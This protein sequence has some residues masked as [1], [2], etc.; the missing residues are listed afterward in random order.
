MTKPTSKKIGRPTKKDATSKRPRGAILA[1]FL[2]QPV[3]EH[4]RASGMFEETADHRAQSDHDD[5]EAQRVAEA[6]L[7]R[8]EDLFRRH[9]RGQAERHAGE[10]QRQKRVQ[11]YGEDQDQE[12]RDRNDRKE[13]EIVTV[14]GHQCILTSFKAPGSRQNSNLR[15]IKA[16]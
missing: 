9:V 12:Q 7:D 16:C 15:S 8:L 6:G 1:E 14:G 13:N 2:H 10:Q 3:G 11:L 5:D 4:L